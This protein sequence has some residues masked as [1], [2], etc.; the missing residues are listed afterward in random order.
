MTS[1]QMHEMKNKINEEK[2]DVLLTLAWNLYNK[3]NA[4]KCLISEITDNYFRLDIYYSSNPSKQQKKNEK[5]YSSVTYNFPSSPILEPL[6]IE[7]SINKLLLDY[8]H[9]TIP[10]GVMPFIMTFIWVI[11]FIASVHDVHTLETHTYL[12]TIQPYT[13]LIFQTPAYALA[14]IAITFSAHIIEG[15]YVSYLCNRLNIN[16]SFS[17]Q[18]LTLTLFLGFPVTSQVMYLYRIKNAKNEV[19]RKNE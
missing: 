17:V 8:S 19:N 12:R 3:K 5:E 6:K 16:K 2:Q 4:K 18:Y 15:A 9:V 7:N 10:P 11:M 14:L 13:L 1:N